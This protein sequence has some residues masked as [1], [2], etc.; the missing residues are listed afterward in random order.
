MTHIA[1]TTRKA[2]LTGLLFSGIGRAISTLFVVSSVAL[3]S[4]DERD[5]VAVTPLVAAAK[6]KEQ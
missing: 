6:S 5:A 4:K 3:L 1:Q 2:V